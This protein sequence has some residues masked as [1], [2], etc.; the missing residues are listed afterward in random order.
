MTCRNNDAS[1]T[2]AKKT[3]KIIEIVKEILFPGT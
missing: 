1:I 3:R 2:K